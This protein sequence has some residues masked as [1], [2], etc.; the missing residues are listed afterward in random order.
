M[1]TD[2]PQPAEV[3][4]NWRSAGLR[5]MV[6]GWRRRAAAG[7]QTRTLALPGRVLRVAV[8]GGNPQWPPLVLCNGIGARLELLQPFVDALD[9][10]RAVIRFDLPVIGGSPPPV[11]PYHLWT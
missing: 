5:T 10:Q 4:S 11:I 8:R 6:K 7:E 9:P 1:T 3:G 2:R